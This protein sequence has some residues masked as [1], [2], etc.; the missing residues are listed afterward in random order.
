MFEHIE[1]LTTCLY[2]I[3]LTFFTDRFLL[4]NES[5]VC[6]FSI[7]QFYFSNI[8]IDHKKERRISQISSQ[9]WR[10]TFACLKMC[11]V[12]TQLLNESFFFY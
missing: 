5:I 2:F 12:L 10:F 6:T 3:S 7:I 1:G 11:E 8:Y 9:K 4:L